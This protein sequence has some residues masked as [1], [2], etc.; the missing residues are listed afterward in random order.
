MATVPSDRDPRARWAPDRVG[1]LGTG[2]TLLILAG[3]A[4]I[5]FVA[6]GIAALAVVAGVLAYLLLPL[7]DQL[8]RKGM[9]RTAAAWTVFL[10]LVIV[11]GV[12]TALGAPSNAFANTA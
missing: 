6:P 11:L 10:G 12:L 8:E 9:G 3:I 1:R 5:V 4:A 7:V 2:T